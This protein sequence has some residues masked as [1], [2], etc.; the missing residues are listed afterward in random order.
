MF[1]SNG[2]IE[3]PSWTAVRLTPDLNN[4]L[5]NI[6]RQPQGDPLYVEALAEPVEGQPPVVLYPI[7]VNAPSPYLSDAVDQSFTALRQ[8]VLVEAGW[9]FL[10]QLDGMFEELTAR[11]LPGQPARPAEARRPVKAGGR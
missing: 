3:D 6:D 2:R 10:G 5:Q 9:D 1:V 11:P 4:R 7:A 8:R